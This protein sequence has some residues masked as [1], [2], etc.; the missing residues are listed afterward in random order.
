MSHLQNIAC[1][2]AVHSAFGDIASKV[3]YVGGAT[4]S[5]YVDRPAGQIRPTLDVDV[6]VELANYAGYAELE[7]N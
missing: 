6:L 5:L 1:I 4:V 3:V 7:E 2:K